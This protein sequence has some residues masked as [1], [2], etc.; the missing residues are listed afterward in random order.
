M[1]K[2]PDTEIYRPRNFFIALAAGIVFG[3]IGLA[4]LVA[5]VIPENLRYLQFRDAVP[6]PVTE[7]LHAELDWTDDMDGSAKVL[8]AKVLVEYKYMFDDR[9]YVGSSPSIYLGS[10]NL[11]SFQ[12]DLFERIK[13]FR[14][15]GDPLTCY[16]LETDPARS[17]L[18]R[19]F[20]KG[21][22]LLSIVL[23]LLSVAAGGFLTG[24]PLWNRRRYFSPEQSD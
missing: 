9:E 12:S 7:I 18:D 1:T 23:S 4:L 22:G 14:R 16:V 6:V 8:S 24:Y 2:L 19:S 11:G 20:R 5:L 3:S 10:D 17:V 15:D 13:R 21:R